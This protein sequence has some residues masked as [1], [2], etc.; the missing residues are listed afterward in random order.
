MTQHAPL[1]RRTILAL[2]AI[3]LVIVIVTASRHELFRDEVRAVLIAHRASSLRDMVVLLHNDAHPPL[4]HLLLRA[5]SYVAGLHI[6]KPVAILVAVPAVF[7]FVTYSPFPRYQKVLFV[8]GVL[9]LYEYSVMCR[10]YGLVML[11]LFVLAILW[12]RRF[13]RPLPV[14]IT[15]VLL[16]NGT[17]H[18][19][20]LTGVI[21]VM[22]G[23][24]YLA[25][26]P[27]TVTFKTVLVYLIPLPAMALAAFVLYPDR[28]AEGTWIYSNHAVKVLGAVAASLFLPLDFARPTVGLVAELLLTPLLFLLALAL[29]ERVWLTIGVVLAAFMFSMFSQLVG[30]VHLRHCGLYFMFVLFIYWIRSHGEARQLSGFA[31]RLQAWSLRF[32]QPTLGLVLLVCVPAGLICV[33]DDIWGQRSSSKALG[34]LLQSTPRLRSAIVV[35][36]TP[37]MTEALPYYADNRI[38]LP[39]EGVFYWKRVNFSKKLPRALDLEQV[40]ADANRLGADGTPV[41][42]VLKHDIHPEGPFSIDADCYDMVF[43]YSPEAYAR[44][45]SHA[46]LLAKLDQAYASNENYFVYAWN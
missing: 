7:L 40:T 22:L 33:N 23:V 26:R 3:Y 29:L 27:Q 25:T 24:E 6:L 35:A 18:G 8:F 45:F 4:W 30:E 19:L 2:I 1:Q 34:D 39:R 42:V 13:T 46:R 21:L 16:A 20:I 31:A 37:I 36:E 43:T 5:I 12:G 10:N 11:L 15:L 14:A 44:F 32:A 9:P 38:Y 17:L 28:S 41:V